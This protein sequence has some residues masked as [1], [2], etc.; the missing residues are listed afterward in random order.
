MWFLCSLASC[1]IQ[2]G[3]E[4]NSM[5]CVCLCLKGKKRT[6]TQRQVHTDTQTH[7]HTDTQT[8]RHTDTDT[9]LGL[10]TL[11]HTLYRHKGSTKGSSALP[12][13]LNRQA[14]KSALSKGHTTAKQSICFSCASFCRVAD[15]KSIHCTFK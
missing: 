10:V 14:S 12:Q 8:H 1:A 2:E 7:R 6:Q 3:K 9:Y 11:I 5:P 13:T 4:V 15:C